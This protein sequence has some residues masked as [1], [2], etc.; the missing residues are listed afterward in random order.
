MVF[1]AVPGDGPATFTAGFVTINSTTVQWE[2]V[3]CLH[4]NGEITSY[5]VLA[6]TIGED[7][8]ELLMLIMAMQEQPLSMD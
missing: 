5:T 8:K 7:D 6:T 1:S 4:R 2:E 3:P